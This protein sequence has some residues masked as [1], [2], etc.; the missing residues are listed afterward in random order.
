MNYSNVIMELLDRIDVLEREQIL[1]YAEALDT[2]GEGQRVVEKALHALIRNKRVFVYEENG[3]QY[4]S[5]TPIK[6]LAGSNRMEMDLFWVQLDAMPYSQNFSLNIMRTFQLSY[7][8]QNNRLV[9]VA[10]IPRNQEK[11]VCRMIKEIPENA[12]EKEDCRIALLQDSQGADKLL[13]VGFRY[14]VAINHEAQEPEDR[15]MILKEFHGNEIWEDI[16][17]GIPDKY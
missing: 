11:V 7:V 5:R 1:W 4:L 2:Y 3:T 6:A 13:R 12:Y 9:Q 17:Y 10:Y 16:N 15:L 14:V 8:N